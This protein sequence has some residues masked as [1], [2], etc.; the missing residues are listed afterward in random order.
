M[1]PRGPHTGGNFRPTVRLTAFILLV[2][3]VAALIR[4]AGTFL[5]AENPLAPADAILVLAGSRLERPL[6]AA[7]LYRDGYAARIVLTADRPE[8]GYDLLAARGIRVPS[9]AEQA[10]ALLGRLGIPADAMEVPPR[11]HDNTA[12]EAQTL[13]QLATARGWRRVIVVSSRYHLRRAGFAMRRE[14]SG[15]GVDVRMRGSR[16][17]PANPSRWWATRRD[18]RWMLSEAPK[19]VAYV[20]GLGA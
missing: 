14:F 2:V 11:I 19:L 13:R 7:D 4:F 6:E 12:Q 17:D 18:V 8:A 16:Y 5:D 15:T 3:A 9:D 1:P 20:L 10:R